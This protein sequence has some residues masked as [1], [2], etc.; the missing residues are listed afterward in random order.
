M[1]YN[2]NFLGNTNSP[3]LN[4]LNLFSQ[5]GF[6]KSGSTLVSTPTSHSGIAWGYISF[7]P[8]ESGQLQVDF[9]VSSEKNYDM[10]QVH[11]KDNYTKPN[12]NDTNAI[13]YMKITGT[14]RQTFTYNVVAGTTYVLHFT[15]AKDG[16][17]T[18]GTD[19]MTI[20]RVTIPGTTYRNNYSVV[21]EWKFGRSNTN[22][23]TYYGYSRSTYADYDE[24]RL[25][26]SDSYIRIN[27]SPNYLAGGYNHYLELV[28]Q[29]K[30][31]NSACQIYHV[32]KYSG[33]SETTVYHFNINGYD[34]DFVT[35]L[36]PMKNIPN[37]GESYFSSIRFDLA[38]GTVNGSI[39][40]KSIRLVVI[41]SGSHVN[42]NGVW[43]P[44]YPS[45]NV[46]GVWKSTLESVNVNGVWKRYI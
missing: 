44:S 36:I 33:E 38:N 17:G 30:S 40:V 2:L 13:A 43:R 16:S 1:A 31:G 18:S 29:N 3:Q 37:W 25:T 11:L 6:Y 14:D 22:S 42:V 32:D 23:Y 21:R 35:Y 28:V 9:E 5:G 19:N 12:R 34:N 8:T 24:Y 39:C 7:C 26:S 41:N 45:V 20:Y 46:G 10:A 15:Y 4:D 27:L